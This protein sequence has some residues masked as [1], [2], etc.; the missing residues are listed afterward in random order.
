M[1]YV[2]YILATAAAR[3]SSFCLTLRNMSSKEETRLWI[4]FREKEAILKYYERVNLVSKERIFAEADYFR[5][6]EKI[7]NYTFRS[8]L[9]HKQS[10]I[11]C[12]K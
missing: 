10:G 7:Y 5:A 1:Y 12:S 2:N 8:C 6:A 9:R 4:E 3:L 11:S